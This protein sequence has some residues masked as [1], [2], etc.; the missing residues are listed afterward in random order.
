MNDYR[1]TYKLEQYKLTHSRYIQATDKSHALE[2]FHRLIKT[3]HGETM[4]EVNTV[5]PVVERDDQIVS[6]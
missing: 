1:I 2:L 4:V 3:V 5:E 6:A